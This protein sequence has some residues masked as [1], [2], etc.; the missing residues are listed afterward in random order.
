MKRLFSWTTA[1]AI[2]LA[3]PALGRAQSPDMPAQPQADQAKPDAPKD[4]SS[5]IMSWPKNAKITARHL[6][7][8]YGP[9]DAATDWTLSWNNHGPWSRITLLRRGPSDAFPTAHRDVVENTI[10]YDVPEEKA[11][12]LV[13]FNTALDVDRV[14]GT[15]SARSDSE[16]ANT[17]ALNMADEIV[18][19]K[20]DAYAARD[21]MRSTLNK[22][23]SG[24]SSPYMD[25]LLF[26]AAD[27]GDRKN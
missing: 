11:G 18:R 13:K 25:H 5:L 3:L 16:A 20:R 26:P 23:M 9:P 24:K 14:N 12:Q 21:F 4:A 6:L 19:G 7:H 8:K 1:A 10:Q 17:L 27:R 22:A 15:L 2:A